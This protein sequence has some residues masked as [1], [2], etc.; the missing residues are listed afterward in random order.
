MV[1]RIVVTYKADDDL[2]SIFAY[3]AEKLASPAAIHFAEAV[4]SVYRN[5]IGYPEM[6]GFVPDKRLAEKGYRRA[7]IHN[8]VM[9]YLVDKEREEVKIVRFFY[10]KRNYTKYL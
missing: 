6:Y 5:L 1:Y 4:E 7:V 2:N 3:I 8:Y 9:L 10:G